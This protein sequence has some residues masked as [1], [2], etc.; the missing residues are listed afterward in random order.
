MSQSILVKGTFRNNKKCC[1]GTHNT[2]NNRLFN[3]DEE[4][5]LYKMVEENIISKIDK[6]KKIELYADDDGKILDITRVD[7][8]TFK[9]SYNLMLDK[10]IS[11]L[12]DNTKLIEIK[13]I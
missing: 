10:Y 1:V 6:F 11:F 13:S 7:V 9:A 4:E 12:N 8:N 2:K 3:K 5:F